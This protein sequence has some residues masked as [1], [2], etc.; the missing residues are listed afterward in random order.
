MMKEIEEEEEAA[1]EALVAEIL[2][3]EKCLMQL[4][5]IAVKRVRYHSNQLMVDQYI[6]KIATQNTRS[7]KVSQLDQYN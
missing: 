1:A 2:V 5:A 7:S 6:V 4:A 3:Q